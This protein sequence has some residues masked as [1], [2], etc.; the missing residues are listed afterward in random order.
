MREL[1]P[2]VIESQIEAEGGLLLALGPWPNQKRRGEVGSPHGLVGWDR[3]DRPK[4]FRP[5]RVEK[6]NSQGPGKKGGNML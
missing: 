5:K 6:R 3:G 4:G 1:G 2:I